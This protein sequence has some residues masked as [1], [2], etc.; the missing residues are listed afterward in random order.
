M[1][2]S[3]EVTV[4]DAAVR[5]GDCEGGSSQGRMQQSGEVTVKE[6]AVRG[7]DSVMTVTPQGLSIDWDKNHF[8]RDVIH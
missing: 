8:C 6:A 4:K 7:G 3:G 1:Q 2:Q 5:E